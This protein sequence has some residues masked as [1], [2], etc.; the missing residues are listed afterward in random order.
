MKK[1]MKKMTAMALTTLVAFGTP[2]SGG[3]A[4]A[5]QAE[6][7]ADNA[8]GTVNESTVVETENNYMGQRSG[9]QSV[10]GYLPPEYTVME[11]TAEEEAEFLS[12]LAARE[13]D[14]GSAWS[15][16]AGKTELY[17]TKRDAHAGASD[18]YAVYTNDFY[19]NNLKNRREKVL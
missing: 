7:S 14:G 15:D 10:T 5:V 12:A 3:A 9:Q 1:M 17:S 6:G 16:E 11:M 18:E 19:Y 2:F 13:Q 8:A 4:E